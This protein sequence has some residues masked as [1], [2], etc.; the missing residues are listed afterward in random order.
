MANLIFL[1]NLGATLYM[2]GLIWFVQ[3]VHYPLF[4]EVM[5]PDFGVY[6][7][8]H[9]RLTTLI[10]MPPMLIEIGTAFLLLF[11]RPP[12]FPFWAVLSIGY[13]FISFSAV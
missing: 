13:R 2:V 12:A 3:I 1:A 11:F 5:R 6:E 8:L 9:S 4:S 7:A 10:V